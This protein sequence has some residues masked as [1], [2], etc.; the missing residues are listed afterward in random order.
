MYFI[1]NYFYNKFQ[2][3]NNH[4]PEMH[5]AMHVS[6]TV[7]QKSDRISHNFPHHHK[8]FVPHKPSWHYSSQR[9]IVLFVTPNISPNRF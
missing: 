4:A 5:G 3:E 2:L 1:S 7:K 8:R 9:D 6:Y